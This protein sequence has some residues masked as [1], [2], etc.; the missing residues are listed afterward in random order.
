M[1][2]ELTTKK[3]INSFRNKECQTLY[4]N[5]VKQIS[6]SNFCDLEL[7]QRK[8]LYAHMSAQEADP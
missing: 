2:S 7:K 8:Q 3:S 1:I 5:A 4:Y 6:S